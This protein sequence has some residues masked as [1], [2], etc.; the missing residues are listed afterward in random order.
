MTQLPPEEGGLFSC[1]FCKFT[2]K[3][4]AVVSK[5]TF[6]R[7]STW[8]FVE[9]EG[10]FFALRLSPTVKVVACKDLDELRRLYK[11]YTTNPK[12]GFSLVKQPVAA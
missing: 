1:V 5:T 4:H 2:V 3:V 12:Y 11:R 6:G 7:L 10:K 9:D 8:K